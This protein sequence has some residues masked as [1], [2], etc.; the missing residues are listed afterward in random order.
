[1]S[2]GDTQAMAQPDE[3]LMDPDLAQIMKTSWVPRN[4]SEVSLYKSEL[5]PLMI[6]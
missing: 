5:L 6:L 2:L 1:M 3:M 4:S